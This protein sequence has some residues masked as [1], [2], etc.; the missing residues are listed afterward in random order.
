ML[1][2][3]NPDPIVVTAYENAGVDDLNSYYLIACYE[4]PGNKA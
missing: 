3:F 1:S 2:G 4:M